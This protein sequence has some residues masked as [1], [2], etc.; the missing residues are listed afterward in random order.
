MFYY[1][2]FEDREPKQKKTKWIVLTVLILS[3]FLGFSLR[4]PQILFKDSAVYSKI[5]Q[6]QGL[7]LDVP[8]INEK[9]NFIAG[10]SLWDYEKNKD[11]SFLVS[12]KSFFDNNWISSNNETWKS[13]AWNKLS[14]SE[15]VY[16]TIYNWKIEK[17]LLG[18]RVVEINKKT[19]FVFISQEEREEM[20]NNFIS[21]QSKKDILSW[22]KI[23]EFLIFIPML[24]CVWAFFK[25][26]FSPK[27][28]FFYSSLFFSLCP[29]WIL[30][31]Y[32]MSPLSII[33]IF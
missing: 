1:Q 14:N 30:I 26:P 2:K 28:Y 29:F 16:Q 3:I 24:W 32:L 4:V 5:L 21:S 19:N 6:L 12:K 11:N 18:Y 13:D 22:L 20:K 7:S 8:I 17:W 31:N 27:K 15:K 10:L 23:I 33:F 9:E 25:I